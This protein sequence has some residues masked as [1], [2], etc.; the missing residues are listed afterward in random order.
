M[1]VKQLKVSAAAQ[2][3][4]AINAANAQLQS[5]HEFAI[6]N[7]ETTHNY[8][9]E[10]LAEEEVKTV[11]ELLNKYTQV[12]EESIYEHYMYSDDVGGIIFY[13][14]A[15]CNLVAYYDYE[16]F[17]GTLFNVAI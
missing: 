9:D 17:W 10:A 5:L 3:Q 12:F 14:N 11:K 6:N 2:Q 13:Y 4:F 8:E 7:T 1:Q 16:N 15:N